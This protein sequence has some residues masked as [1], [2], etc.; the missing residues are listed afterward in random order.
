M[1]NETGRARAFY[2]AD[3]PAAWGR[4][5]MS[6]ERQ[7]VAGWLERLNARGPTI[8][9][10][11]GAGALAGLG[12]TY[13]ALDLALAPLR[14]IGGR[15]V[16]ADMESIPFRNATVGCI[17]SWAAMEHVPHP[18][19]VLAEITRVLRA[20]GVAILAPA[21]HCRPW[22][23][24]G[25]EFREYSALSATQRIRKALIPFRNAIWWRAIF[26]LPRRLRREWRGRSKPIDF[27]Y[28]KLTPNLD[29][30]VGTDSDAFTSMDPEAMAIWFASRGWDVVSH[31][32]FS[33]RMLARHEPVVVRKP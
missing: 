2:D 5:E 8:E 11:C 7:R 15:A 33:N 17:F 3:R 16:L 6:Q 10:G 32:S 28:R 31:R 18:E 9:L 26:E 24:E 29:E 4:T 19:R 1:K 13:V 12:E 20:D 22:A 23:A 30:Y 25:L 21:W 14:R 27:E